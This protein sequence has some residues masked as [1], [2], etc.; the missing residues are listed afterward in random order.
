MLVS[1]LPDI[2][3]LS[4]A[5]WHLMRAQHKLP[6]AIFTEDKR[7]ELVKQSLQAYIP[8]VRFDNVELE[9]DIR[10]GE[11]LLRVRKGDK[12]MALSVDIETFP[13]LTPTQFALL[14]LF[15]G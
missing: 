9:E 1:K 14:V 10:T 12:V 11:H 5:G 3:K 7:T 6:L 4:P 8:N 2:A 15:A 13:E